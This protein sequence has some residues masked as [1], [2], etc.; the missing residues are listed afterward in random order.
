MIGCS[1]SKSA[2]KGYEGGEI[3]FGTFGGFS[4]AY[5]ESLIYENGKTFSKRSKK[6]E[7]SSRKDISEGEA[8]RVFRNYKMIGLDTIKID[9][10]GT[11]TYFIQIKHDGIDNRMEW[12]MNGKQVNPKVNMFYNILKN[13]VKAKETEEAAVR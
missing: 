9:E 4:N 7:F 8:K 12:G 5:K 2:L 11:F 3:R 1:T 6:G 13:L 10:P